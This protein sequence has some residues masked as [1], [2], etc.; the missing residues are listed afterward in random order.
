[1]E[2]L[3]SFCGWLTCHGPG[4]VQRLRL[5]LQP[6]GEWQ[7][8]PA[9]SP[10]E[11]QEL[12]TLLAAALPACAGSLHDLQLYLSGGSAQHEPFPTAS[13]LPRLGSQLH[14]LVSRR[15]KGAGMAALG[16]RI[17]HGSAL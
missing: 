8:E 16:G 4:Q 3:R 13:W 2:R 11:W 6:A 9:L 15:L 1:M 7:R 14:R 5:S 10:A 12:C 17:G